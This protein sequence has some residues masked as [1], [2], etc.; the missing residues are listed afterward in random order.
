MFK[1]KKKV[2]TIITPSQQSNDVS[3]GDDK[4]SI[5]QNMIIDQMTVALTTL[6]ILLS[7]SSYIGNSYEKFKEISI[8]NDDFRKR[9]TVITF[10]INK[11]V[12]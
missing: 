10:S 7:S 2:C 8:L 4:L 1:R 5:D 9:L 12:K 11:I 3:N 6:Q